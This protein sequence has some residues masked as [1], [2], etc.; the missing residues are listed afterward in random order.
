MGGHQAWLFRP[1]AGDMVFILGGE[2]VVQD[3]IWKHE[4]P[5]GQFKRLR[6]T[7]QIRGSIGLNIVKLYG[8]NKGMTNHELDEWE[9]L[10]RTYRHHIEEY[11]E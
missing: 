1:F 2:R 11:Y 10:F 4:I 5:G 7:D 8:W 6:R 3:F 9:C